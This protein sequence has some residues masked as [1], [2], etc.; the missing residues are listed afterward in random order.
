M[1]M[2][3]AL[4]LAYTGEFG[5]MFFLMG[6]ILV[7]LFGIFVAGKS[8]DDLITSFCNSCHGSRGW[9]FFLGAFLFVFGILLYVASAVLG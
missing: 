3:Y 4:W 7:A 9:L 6:V 8:K 5:K 2:D 1:E